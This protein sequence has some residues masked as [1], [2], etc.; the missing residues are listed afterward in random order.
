MTLQDRFDSK[1]YAISRINTGDVKVTQYSQVESYLRNQQGM[2]KGLH[3]NKDIIV[4]QVTPDF[5]DEPSQW[6]PNAD[7]E[8]IDAATGL[9]LGFNDGFYRWWAFNAEVGEKSE[10]YLDQPEATYITRLDKWS[11]II[12]VRHDGLTNTYQGKDIIETVNGLREVCVTEYVGKFS[13]ENKTD[14]QSITDIYV[15]EVFKNYTDHNEVVQRSERSYLEYLLADKDKSDKTPIWGYTDYVKTLAGFV[16]NNELFGIDPL[17]ANKPEDQPLTMDM[18]LEEL[19]Q[20][21]YPVQPNDTL[22]FAMERENSW[23]GIQ[24]GIYTWNLL[25]D[26]NVEW[27][28]YNNLTESGLSGELFWEGQAEPY[29]FEERYFVDEH[30][31][32]KG[33]EATENGEPSIK[34][35]NVHTVR[36]VVSQP[37]TYRIPEVTNIQLRAVDSSTQYGDWETGEYVN[38]TVFVGKET[39]EYVEDGVTYTQ[40]A[41]RTYSYEKGSL[42]SVEGVQT[43]Q[44]WNSQ[45]DWYDNNGLVYRERENQ[46]RKY[47][48]WKRIAVNGQ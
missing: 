29:T 26:S 5:G 15:E 12:P 22:T 16:A 34:W 39:V 42:Y 27:Q 10:L 25:V 4:S 19:D 36:E 1:V 37:S 38:S 23:G 14:D 28:G 41:C 2:P 32:W 6:D 43:G 24:T 17:E 47:E 21:I 46:D 20:G 11:P 9:Y 13:F 30:G 45:N 7:F 40:D 44:E 35:G 3:E 48:H 31:V 8:Y 18:C 33:M